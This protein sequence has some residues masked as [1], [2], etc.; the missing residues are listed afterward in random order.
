MA[1]KSVYEQIKKQNGEHFA[2][3]IRNY[4][5]GIF[6]VPGI[7]DIVKYAGHEAEPIMGYLESLKKI[8]IEETGVYQD[9]LTLLDQAG[10]DAYYVTNLE[11]QNRIEGYYA[12][13]RDLKR[14]GIKPPGPHGEKLCTFREP[15]R[16]QKYYIIHAVKKDADRFKR[17]AFR[18]I[19][20]REDD[21]GTSVI[22]IQISKAGGLISIKNR[23]NHTVENCDNTFDS[24]PDKIIP[25]LSNSLRHHFNVDFSSKESKLPNGYTSIDGKIVRYNFERDDIY[26]GSDFYVKDGQIHHLKPHEIMLDTHIFDLRTKKLIYPTDR[27]FRNEE[28]TTFKKV[29]LGEIKGHKVIF[30]KDKNGQ[31]LFIRKE[32]EKDP[33]KDV[34]ILTVKDGRITALNLPTTEKIGDDFMKKTYLRSFNAPHVKKMGNNCLKLAG[35]LRTVNLPNLTTM[36]NSCIYVTDLETIDLPNLKKI[37]D[38]CF[39]QPIPLKT[40]NLPALREMGKYCFQEVKSLT[41]LNLPALEQMR[42]S[43][44]AHSYQLESI[45]IPNLVTMGGCCFY[46]VPKL[47]ELNLLSLEKMANSCISNSPKLESVSLPNLT[48]MGDSCFCNLDSLKKLNLPLLPRL[49]EFCFRYTEALTSLNLPSVTQMAEGC[50]K[51]A[52]SLDA[53]RLPNIREMGEYCFGGTQYM[54]LFYAPFLKDIPKTCFPNQ[55]GRDE[56]LSFRKQD[57]TRGGISQ[58]LRTT[59]NGQENAPTQTAEA[60]KGISAK[61]QNIGQVQQTEQSYSFLK[62]LRDWILPRQ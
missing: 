26:F 3:T 60:P 28:D 15:D 49:R 29:L 48:D 56:L 27:F 61:L 55:Y 16:F 14:M 19:E 25:G 11:E 44:F 20:T 17:E 59:Q 57:P 51:Y 38:C 47:T 37:G 36:G 35:S 7:V 6:D 46:Y 21:Y 30:K 10:Y 52:R 18:G 45:N 12:S 9:P 33:A 32:G 5:N 54:L 8:H 1:K 24:N 50:F 2:Q 31:H 34:E 62:R 43:C 42:E 53:V 13:A 22:S 23:Y 4:D 58:S 40:L 39:N 41:S